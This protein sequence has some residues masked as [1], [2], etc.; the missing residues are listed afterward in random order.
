MAG[1]VLPGHFRSVPLMS[2]R[3]RNWCFT[4]FTDVTN[5]DWD[6]MRTV[7][8][9][10]FQHELCPRTAQDH[11]Q[12]YIEFT[13]ATRMSAVK[14]L[15]EDRSVH[16]EARRGTREQARAYCMK[17]DTRFPGEEPYEFGE[18]TGRQGQRTDLVE[19]RK[20]IESSPSWVSVLRNDD[21]TPAVAR[22]RNWAREVYENRPRE[23]PPPEIQL[24][25]WEKQAIKVLEGKPQK[26]QV[27]WIWS[28]ESG[29]GKSTFFD[30]CSCR[31]NV[32]PGSDYA[33]TLYT[34]DDHP[35]IWFDITRAQSAEHIP[36]HAIEK[37]SNGGY[38]HST[39]Y[40][41]VRKLI[42]AHVV[43]TSNVPPDEEKLPKR[44]KIILASTI[45]VRP[46]SPQLTESDLDD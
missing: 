2:N 3:Y 13:V 9:A 19:A 10:V 11:W 37:F 1:L 17:A 33:N 41:S 30:Y 45:L 44:C 28:A 18:W 16:L 34:Y 38:H 40:V 39:K 21:I 7:R 4:A 29:T 20:V 15:L 35:I 42:L 26:R 5:L 24:Y 36:Y 25:Q 23:M 12:G 27:L 32:L 6:N 14:E 46:P 22:H 43:V 8:Y 31:W